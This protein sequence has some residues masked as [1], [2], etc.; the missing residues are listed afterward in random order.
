MIFW[1]RA[2]I[3]RQFSVCSEHYQFQCL[4]DRLFRI[5]YTSVGLAFICE[6]ENVGT[7]KLTVLNSY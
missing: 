6:K 3:W 7:G 5:H 2:G 4:I 1:Q